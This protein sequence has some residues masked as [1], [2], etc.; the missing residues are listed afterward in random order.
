[1]NGMW[2]SAQVLVL[3]RKQGATAVPATLSQMM[4][5]RQCASPVLWNRTTLLW[6]PFLP[7]EMSALSNL[8]SV[9]MWSV[10]EPWGGSSVLPGLGVW[11]LKGFPAPWLH[12]VPRV[13]RNAE[14]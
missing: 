6:F 5:Y 9:L 1:M 10:G 14:C 2:E 8:K 7:E 3:V 4:G 12:L 11:S 13:H